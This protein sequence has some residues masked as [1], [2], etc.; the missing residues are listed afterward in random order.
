MRQQAVERSETT[1]LCKLQMTANTTEIVISTERKENEG[2]AVDNWKQ[3]NLR[4]DNRRES[5]ESNGEQF[6]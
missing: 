6:E 3:V 5:V 4:H 2:G 1:K